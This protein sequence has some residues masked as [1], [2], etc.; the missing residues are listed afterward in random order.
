MSVKLGEDER[1]L[2]EWDYAYSGSL[3]SKKRYKLAITNKR[4]ITVE[5]SPEQRTEESYVLKSVTGVSVAYG[6]VKGL[7]LMLPFILIAIVIAVLAASGILP[8]ATSTI[9]ILLALWLIMACVSIFGRKSISIDIYGTFT[10]MQLFTTPGAGKSRFSTWFLFGLF[11]ALA[12]KR[13]A[14][15]KVHKSVAKEIVEELGK[16]VFGEVEG[17]SA[18]MSDIIG[19]TK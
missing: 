7:F 5:E 14:R 3:L 10:E 6:R 18:T 17:G 11:G 8:T 4:L 9:Y 15:I 16:A 1:I 2:K 13:T 19:G 12:H